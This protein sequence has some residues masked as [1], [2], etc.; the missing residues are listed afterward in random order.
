VI[1][2]TDTQT[3]ENAEEAT[4]KAFMAYYNDNIPDAFPRATLRT[5]RDFQ[6]QYPSLFK[7][8][9]VWSINKH[10]KKFMDWLSSHREPKE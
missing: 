2:T 8:E 10:R 3:D 6:S 5:L 1:N 7:K 4:P 9:D